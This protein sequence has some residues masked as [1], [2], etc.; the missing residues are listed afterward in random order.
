M[1]ELFEHQSEAVTL[2]E[3]QVKAKNPRMCLHFRTGSGKTIAALAALAATG[4]TEAL[5]VTP[6]VTYDSW[7]EAAQSFGITV[8]T[9]S[10]AKFRMKDYR[11]SRTRPIVMDEFHLLGGNQGKGFKKL[12]RIAR[13]AP[14]L[15]VILLSATPN[16]ND[17]E[18]AYCVEVI[19][20]PERVKGGFLH[21]IYTRCIT[22]PNPFSATPDVEGFREFDS[23]ADYLSSLPEV[24]FLPDTAKYT[25]T[26]IELLVVHSSL[27]EKFSIGFGADNTPRV[28]LSTMGRSRE[29]AYL[30]FLTDSRERIRPGVQD[31]LFELWQQVS[32]SD[33]P[34]L[35]AYC[36]ST[37]IARF[38]VKAFK[39]RF[40]GQ[41]EYLHGKTPKKQRELI[42]ARFLDP[43][44]PVLLVATA[45]LATGFDG[46]DT[47][48]E[49]MVIVE[50]TLDDTLRRQLVG[51]ILPRGTTQTNNATFY[52]LTF[53]DVDNTGEGDVY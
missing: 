21:F 20:N 27:L 17:A 26:P 41:V 10:H 37:T 14:Q 31:E 49:T 7:R 25:L 4:H 15:P 9:I 50:D 13:A 29:Q 38:V 42:L 5:I 45:T 19:L 18:R 51:R 12:S 52:R 16:Y 46:A 34:K 1:A 6:P 36:N 3:R 8:E 22:R 33:K 48:C 32:T 11:V 53:S 30:N 2:W 24:A 44:Q 43:S 28:L 23:A 40:P 47:V 39:K 35:I